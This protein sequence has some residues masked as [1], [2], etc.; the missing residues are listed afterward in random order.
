MEATATHA[1]AKGLTAQRNYEG[2][3]AAERNYEA[4]LATCLVCRKLFPIDSYEK[5]LS[6]ES[7]DF[8]IGHLSPPHCECAGCWRGIPR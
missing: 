2:D 6:G 4:G 1:T 3:L 7:D 5:F 8:V